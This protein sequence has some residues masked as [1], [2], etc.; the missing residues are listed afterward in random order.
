MRRGGECYDALSN[1]ALQRSAVRTVR[2][3]LLCRS[4]PLNAA[5][6]VIEHRQTAE[7]L[8]S[9]IPIH[10]LTFVILM[11][12]TSPNQDVI[13][14][15]RTIEDS[16]GF[17]F[18][19]EFFESGWFSQTMRAEASGTYQATKHLIHLNSKR[20]GREMYR[21]RIEGDTL[22]LQTPKQEEKLTRI[23]NA[24]ASTP[25]LV[26][27]WQRNGLFD[28][29]QEYTMTM[30]FT[31]GGRSRTEMDIKLKGGR[32]DIRGDTL[33]MTNE[34]GESW[35]SS[36]RFEKG[37]LIFKAEHEGG[38]EQKYRRIRQTRKSA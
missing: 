31:R 16:N 8:M 30:E 29:G 9:F 4:R 34:D 14:R 5:F 33:T 22:I 3:T 2:V 24:K 23:S 21:F 36:F 10:L 17:H 7:W 27:R 11:C 13:G 18:I 19:T 38:S 6:G 35:S 15:W 12:Q 1:I 20:M 25:S 26:G 37:R 28:N 32:Y